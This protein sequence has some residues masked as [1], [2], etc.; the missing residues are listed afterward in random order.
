MAI[1]FYSNGI[2]I[3]CYTK[4]HWIEQG[5]LGKLELMKPMIG[6]KVYWCNKVHWIVEAGCSYECK[7]YSPRNK[8]NGCCVNYK[9]AY[10]GTETYIT[11]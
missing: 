9:Y 10:E 8:K 1:K 7:D 4:K 11:I 5:F 2:D 3:E 6:D